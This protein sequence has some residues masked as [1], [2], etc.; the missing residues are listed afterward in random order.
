MGL[1]LSPWPPRRHRIAR[2]LGILELVVSPGDRKITLGH[3]QPALGFINVA[4]VCG[5]ARLPQSK[6]EIFGPF[7]HVVS[8]MMG[9]KSHSGRS[10]PPGM[11]WLVSLLS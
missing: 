8:L 3:L 9:V 2:S 1:R 7:D 6:K 4:L 5:D 10:D 11:L